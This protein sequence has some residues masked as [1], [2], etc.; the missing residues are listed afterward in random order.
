PDAGE[1]AYLRSCEWTSS[2]AC[3]L[4]C[5]CFSAFLGGL[6]VS[7]CCGG[8]FGFF[9]QSSLVVASNRHDCVID[10]RPIEDDAQ[11]VATL[12]RDLGHGRA[13]HLAAGKNHQDLVLLG[14]HQTTRESAPIVVQFGDL[15][16]ESTASL[17]PVLLDLRA[18]RVAAIRD[19]EHGLTGCR[20]G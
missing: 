7:I 12:R 4:L 15:D 14:H 17:D 3:Q 19:D 2:P 16:A 5:S 9:C 13:Y 18:L 6:G 20:D 10:A 8:L 1:P 11:G